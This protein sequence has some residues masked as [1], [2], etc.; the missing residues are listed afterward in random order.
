[1]VLTLSRDIP[2]RRRI[3]SRQRIARGNGLI[4]VLS[5]LKLRLPRYLVIKPGAAI[6]IG[7]STQRHQVLLVSRS[8]V[9]VVLRCAAQ[10]RVEHVEPGGLFEGGGLLL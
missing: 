3:G 1:M 6:G 9:D 4:L 8:E 7:S 2:E 10:V 5:H